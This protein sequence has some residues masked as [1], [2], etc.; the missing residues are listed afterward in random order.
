MPQPLNSV[1]GQFSL[2]IGSLP[3]SSLTERP[4]LAALAMTAIGTFSH[5]EAFQLN[6]FI[7]MMGGAKDKATRIFL[8]LESRSAK[9]SAISA[10]AS[11]LSVEMRGVL[12]AIQSITRSEQKRRD[13]LAHFKWGHIPEKEECLLLQDPRLSTSRENYKDG[14]FVYKESDFTSMIRD[15]HRLG[16]YWGKFN[17]AL[18]GP[19]QITSLRCDQLSQEPRIAKILNRHSP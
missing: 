8:K 12:N 14:I 19:P 10:V 18:I 1:P 5:V 6:A 11:D 13:K 2:E 17:Q 3:P 15:F 4:H 7:E 9:A 16:G